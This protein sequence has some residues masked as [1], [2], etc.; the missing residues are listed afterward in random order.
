MSNAIDADELTE[1]A[2]EKLCQ[3]AWP[4][5]EGWR[6]L[7]RGELVQEGDEV[8]RDGCWQKSG[9]WQLWSRRQ[10]GIMSYRRRID[11]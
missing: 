4:V 8:F 5:G 10:S 6:R 11:E 7:E 3:L 9:N 2:I 1:K